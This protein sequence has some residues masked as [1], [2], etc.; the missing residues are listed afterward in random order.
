MTDKIHVVRA[1]DADCRSRPEV[2]KGPCAAVLVMHRA[3]YRDPVLD[4][5][6]KLGSVD[7]FSIYPNDRGHDWAGFKND[8]PVLAGRGRVVRLLKMFVFSRRYSV[9]VWPAYHPWWLTLPIVMSACLGR[10]YGLMSDT[11][12]ENGGRLSRWIKRIV[13]RHA[14]FI[15]VPGEA[16]SRFLAQ[17]YGVPPDRVVRGL[18]V[19][20]PQ[21][22]AG[23]SAR[24]PTALRNFL[25]V[26]NDIPERRLNVLVAGFRR[27]RKGNE[28]LVL[29]GHGCSRYAG[30]GVFG[31][32]GVK[33]EELPRLYEEAD[34]YVHNGMEQFSTAVQI[35]AFR[36]MPVV[37]SGD[38]GIVADF[39]HAEKSMVVVRDWRSADAWQNAFE[40]LSMMTSDALKGMCDRC[41]EE[42]R[43]LY[44]LESIVA[45]VSGCIM[46]LD[47]SAVGGADVV[48]EMNC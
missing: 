9:V 7:L 22:V 41:R 33:W 37:C 46:D 34:V 15:W 39:A 13:F 20:D 45:N 16:S 24:S 31:R 5:L 40:R 29:C 44:D 42:S 11:K 17:H 35:A 21:E 43:A 26:A 3:P 47:T 18:Y 1:R 25:M 10:R 23:P 6:K 4:R 2:A 27:W 8:V 28:R 32:E 30:E 14:A 36:G 19:V 48:G 12:E 38:I